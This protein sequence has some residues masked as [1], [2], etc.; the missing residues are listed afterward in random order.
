VRVVDEG[1]LRGGKL[2]VELTGVVSEM[3]ANVLGSWSSFPCFSVGR[4]VRFFDRGV[5]AFSALKGAVVGCSKRNV[6]TDGS[7][8]SAG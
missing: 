4:R 8:S 6:A 5:V 7:R 1:L 3:S 2:E